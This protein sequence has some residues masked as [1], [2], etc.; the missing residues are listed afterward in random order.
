MGVAFASSKLSD[1]SEFTSKYISGASFGGLI[2]PPFVGMLLS[3]NP[4]TM[5]AVGSS[6]LRSMPCFH[7]E[8]GVFHTHASLY[9]IEAEE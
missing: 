2:W 4:L 7:G 5:P 6:S 3:A 8:A 9:G 1:S